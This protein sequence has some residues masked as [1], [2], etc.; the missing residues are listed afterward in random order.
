MIRTLWS[1]E[2]GLRVHRVCNGAFDDRLIVASR[3]HRLSFEKGRKRVIFK[4]REGLFVCIDVPLGR[5][6]R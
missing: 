5:R 4:D 2:P 1:G 3:C 6:R